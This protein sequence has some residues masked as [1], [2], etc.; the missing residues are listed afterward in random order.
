DWIRD[1]AKQL[2]V[3][4]LV[5]DDADSMKNV[6]DALGLSHQICRAHVNRN[7][8]DLV[9]ALGTKAVEHPDR[10]PWEVPGLSVEQFLEDV[11]TVEELIKGLPANGQAEMLKLA[12]RYQG[13]PPPPQGGRA[14]MWYRLRLLTLD[15]S[16]NWARLTLFQRWRSPTKQKLDGTNNASEQAIG[17][18]VKERYRTMRTY[19]RKPSI[20]NVSGLLGWLWMQRTDYD[21]GA[22]VRS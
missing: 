9:A 7:V 2:G 20:V 15:W 18:C 8:H 10:V 5:T 12:E 11:E 6:A 17:Q 4:I 22:V 19:K 13:A 14:S 16:E 1:L 21:L 3:E